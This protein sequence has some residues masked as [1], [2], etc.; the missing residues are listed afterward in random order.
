[1][2]CRGG[3]PPGDITEFVLSPRYGVDKICR[4]NLG[5]IAQFEPRA[6]AMIASYERLSANPVSEF[7][8]LLSFI[9]P[10]LVGKVDITEIMRR[11]SFDEM[12]EMERQGRGITRG[13]ES[14]SLDDPNAFKARRGK[15]GGYREE[16]AP[17]AIRLAEER[18]DQLSYNDKI[19]RYL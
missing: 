5:W 19:K 18:I 9:R 8:R 13:Y 16:L 15:V 7:E 12:R 4:F 1:M 2:R 10:D 6:E 17:E 14:I 11:C 3:Y